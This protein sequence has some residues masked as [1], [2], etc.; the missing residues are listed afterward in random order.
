MVGDESGHLY[1][2]HNPLGTQPGAE[3]SIDIACG[4]LL[5]PNP[6]GVA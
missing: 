6:V 1:C 4:S 5:A 3:A 2:D